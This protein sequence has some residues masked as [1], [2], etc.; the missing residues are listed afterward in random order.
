M[1]EEVCMN[2]IFTTVLTAGT[3]A[4]AGSAHAETY[5]WTLGYMGVPGMIYTDVAEVIPERI[6]KAT[7]GQVVITA[8]SSLVTPNRLL[9]A[10]RDGLVDMSL[11]VTAY[12]TGT[13][14]LF[15]VPAMPGA[16]ESLENLKAVDASPY[17][18]QLREVYDADYNSI[19]LMQ[20]AFCPQTI[21]STKPIRTVEEWNGRK[22]RVNN[23]AT[24]LIGEQ[25]GATTI[26]LSANE[27]VP[28][29]ERGVIDGVVTDICWG[30][31]SGI[32]EVVD[33]AS[34][35]QLGSVM[36]APLLVNKSSWDELP[37]DLQEKVAA[38][39][40]Q[41]EADYDIEFQ[42]RADAM[43]GLLEEKGVEYTAI[44][45]AEMMRVYSDEVMTPV[46]DAWR[47]EMSRA[48]FD[49]DATMATVNEA[50]K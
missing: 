27:I 17:G 22:L 33:Y 26:S 37:A 28:A 44:P 11:V 20:T 21:F 31:N 19:E 42:K 34:Y 10:V 14:P 30:Y 24:G 25:L 43:P 36:P 13:Q 45:E 3:L 23:R 15:S 46:M 2:K 40:K 7:D 12:Y 9:E 8:N 35:W 38:E 48:G 29:L 1:Q 18:D 49:A 6:A 5:E 16:V 32:T 41:I 50:T 4:A 47:E 39:L